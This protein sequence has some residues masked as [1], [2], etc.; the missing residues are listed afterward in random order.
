MTPDKLQL[1]RKERRETRMRHILAYLQTNGL[2]DIEHLC[3]EMHASRNE[4]CGLL[5]DMERCDMV[6]RHIIY[7]KKK[8]CAPVYCYEPA[9][10]ARHG[11]RLISLTD[12]VKWA[13]DTARCIVSYPQIASQISGCLS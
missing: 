3:E 4:L 1:A 7:S 5:C 9:S 12:S 10:K 2:T 11:A 6:A 13:N 8:S